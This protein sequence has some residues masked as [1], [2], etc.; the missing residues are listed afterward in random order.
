M[1][2]KDAL[3]R[4]TARLVAR[5]DSL[6]KTLNG[7]LD[8]LLEVS[9]PS[10]VGDDVDAAIECEND[11]IFSQLVEIESNELAQV[12]RA[13]DRLAAGACGRCEFCGGKIPAARLQVL[14]YA[15]SCIVCQRANEQAVSS[16]LL[17]RDSKQWARVRDMSVD[18]A[19]DEPIAHT[20]LGELAMESREPRFQFS[21]SIQV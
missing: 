4:L 15:T 1:A 9:Q 16:E 6:R 13:L 18:D 8:A 11:E 19:E 5:R 7:D 10:G 14:P 2:R 3:M 21:R 12:E 17:N 20:S